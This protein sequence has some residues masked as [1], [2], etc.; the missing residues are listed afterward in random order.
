MERYGIAPGRANGGSTNGDGTVEEKG[1]DAAARV[2]DRRADDV[3][4]NS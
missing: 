4:L 2:E 1:D 3:P